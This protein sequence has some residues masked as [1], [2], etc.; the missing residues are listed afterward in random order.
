MLGTSMSMIWGFP[1]MVNDT[2]L[3][4]SSCDFRLEAL[5]EDSRVASAT[6]GLAIS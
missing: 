5:E 3:A 4:V 6:S 1:T 2:T